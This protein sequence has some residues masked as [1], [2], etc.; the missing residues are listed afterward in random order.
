LFV[1]LAALSD[2]RVLLQRTAGARRIHAW[3]AWPTIALLRLGWLLGH[4]RVRARARAATASAA[5][6]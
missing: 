6:A 5:H 1:L 3:G 4:V 2:A